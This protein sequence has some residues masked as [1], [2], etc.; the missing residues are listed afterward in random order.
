MKIT[1]EN[2]WKRLRNFMKSHTGLTVIISAAFLLG[3]TACTTKT[4]PE[5]EG[6]KYPDALFTL[7]KISMVELEM[8]KKR[9]RR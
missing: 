3:L 6:K 7:G 9:S 1:K 5:E 4:M 2:W 8:P